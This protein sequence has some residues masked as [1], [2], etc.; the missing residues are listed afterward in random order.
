MSKSTKSWNEKYDIAN[1]KGHEIKRVNKD[2]MGMKAGQLML[3]AT[4]KMVAEI[5]ATIPEGEI[6]DT[7]FLRAELAK[8]S[9]TDV[10]CPVTT[11]IFV[12]IICEAS[13]EDYQNGAN[14]SEL[15]PFW[16]VLGEKAPI[17]KK[18][19]FDLEPF[20]TQQSLEAA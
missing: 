2:M 20:L 9:E 13:N 5:I 18:L 14:L 10:T 16:R 11:G 17:R 4:P 12:R 7:G 6:K 1:A 19:S 3:I 8:Q 15:V